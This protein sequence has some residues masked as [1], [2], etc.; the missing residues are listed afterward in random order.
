MIARF[1]YT[2]QDWRSWNYRDRALA[3]YLRERHPELLPAWAADAPD[4]ASGSPREGPY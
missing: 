2:W 4:P 3:G 1:V